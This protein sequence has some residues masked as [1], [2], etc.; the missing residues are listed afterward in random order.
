MSSQDLDAKYYQSHALI[1]HQLAQSIL[2]THSLALDESI[3][4]IGCGDGHLTAQMAKIASQGMVL[5]IDPSSNMIQFASEQ[6][7]QSNLSFKRASAE[8][9]HG[10]SMYSLVTSF[11]AFHW[12]H[13]IKSALNKIYRALKPSGKVLLLMCP[14]ESLYWQVFIDALQQEGWQPEYNAS[15]VPK[16]PTSKEMLLLTQAAGF[17]VLKS[18]VSNPVANYISIQ[19]FKDYVNGWLACLID[20][21]SEQRE[22]YLQTVTEQMKAQFSNGIGLSIPYTKLEMYLEK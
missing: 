1:Q 21:S 22:A 2:K 11:N 6:Y 10:D 20:C 7:T 8:D 4:D 18:E 5:G 9:N 16:L 17:S 13:D 15:C 12:V 14:R 3:L 19:D